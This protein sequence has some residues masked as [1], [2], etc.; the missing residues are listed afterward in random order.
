MSTDSAQRL[1]DQ[2]HACIKKKSFVMPYEAPLVGHNHDGY[3]ADE[4]KGRG[5]SFNSLRY[6]RTE[7]PQHTIE[8]NPKNKNNQE[9][10][11]VGV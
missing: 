5:G 7:M 11:A 2:Q 3:R 9:G 8:A 10:R 6:C 4:Q 1:N